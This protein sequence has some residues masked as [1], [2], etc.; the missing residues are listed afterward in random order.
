MASLHDIRRDYT[1]EPLPE[2]VAGIDPWNLFE[3]WVTVALAADVPDATAITLA[4][5]G[6]D[7]R[8]SA[9]IVLLKQYSPRG[10][11]FYTDYRSDKGRDLEA[12]PVAS[13]S[14]WWAPLTRQIRA[15]G[16]VTKLPR[17]ESAAYFANRPRGSQLEAWA[18]RQ[19]AP[20][21]SREELQRSFAEADARFAGRGVECPPDWGG[22]LIDVDTFEFWQGL[23]SR[24]H[25]RIRCVRGESGWS[26]QRLQP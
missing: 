14:F 6:R 24:L 3:E 22:Y 17:E 11:V 12:N 7:L 8:P 19:S 23:P 4:T 10:L 13:A 21:P 15:T 16:T 18:S 5:V 1:G 25:D 20:M 9:R 26:T 2:E